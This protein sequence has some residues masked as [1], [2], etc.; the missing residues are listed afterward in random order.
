M[1]GH[2]LALPEEGKTWNV[3]AP[4]PTHFLAALETLA[5]PPPYHRDD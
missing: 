3:S 5:V 2:R 4:F 1:R